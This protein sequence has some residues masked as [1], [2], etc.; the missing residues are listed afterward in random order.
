MRL[1]LYQNNW[2]RDLSSR[3]QEHICNIRNQVIL[4]TN[5]FD[6]CW[7]R[8]YFMLWCYPLNEYDA[9]TDVNAIRQLQ[10]SSRYYC[11][12]DNLSTRNRITFQLSAGRPTGD[13]GVSTG[14]R[15]TAARLHC[16][17]WCRSLVK[18]G[19]KSCGHFLTFVENRRNV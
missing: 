3:P 18:N 19:R 12:Y 13:Y 2:S 17:E 11:S 16:Q 7:R 1:S 4:K 8:L 15:H 10:M 9:L 5:C 14:T 6:H